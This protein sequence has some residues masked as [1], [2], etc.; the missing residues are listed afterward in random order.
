MEAG[1]AGFRPPTQAR[2]RATLER[3]AQA[4][5]ALLAERGPTGVTVG[6]IVERA[7]ASV[8]SF[9]ARFDDKDVAIRYVHERF[10][11]ELWERWE[12]YLRP[13]RWRGLPAMTVVAELV[14]TLVRMQFR[15]APRLRA[16]MVAALM[17]PGDGLTERTAALDRYVAE[18][19][20]ALLAVPRRGVESPP[21]RALAA[22]GFLRVLSAV[23]D[24]VVLGRIPGA[25][26]SAA[27]RERIVVLTRMYGGLL[28]L[29]GLPGSYTELL[30]LCPRRR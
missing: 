15:E 17:R 29:G 23:R 25:D 6:D 5:D 12:S 30:R 16:F 14:R 2:S 21:A 7:S 13:S 10:W 3:I 8:G 26:P 19:V 11:A 20:A 18:G 28:G 22:S 9:Y 24:D 27:A 1:T 4:T